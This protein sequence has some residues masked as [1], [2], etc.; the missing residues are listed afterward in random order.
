MA[1]WRTLWQAFKKEFPDFEGNK[2]YKADVGPQMDDFEK[3]CQDLNQ[4]VGEVVKAFKEAQSIG[5]SLE[6]AVKGYSEIVKELAKADKNIAKEFERVMGAGM[7]RMLPALVAFDK[8][9]Q[10]VLDYNTYFN[11]M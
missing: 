8:D 5:K 3:A 11:V 6:S 1:K 9:L 10:D 4:R 2:R 7:T